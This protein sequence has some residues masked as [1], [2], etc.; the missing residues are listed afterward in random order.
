MSYR[1]A[2]GVFPGAGWC[3]TALVSGDFSVP[4]FGSGLQVTPSGPQ[5]PRLR[6][7]PVILR[8]CSRRTARR[9]TALI[10]GDF[11]VPALGSGFR[12]T[13]SDP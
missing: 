1:R 6:R 8:A 13:P 2:P 10:S 12:V 7:V 3:V 11:F 4:A 9:V 5:C